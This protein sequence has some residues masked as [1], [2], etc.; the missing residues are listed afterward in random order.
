MAEDGVFFRSVARIDPRFHTPVVS[1]WLQ[2]AWAIVLVMTGSY[3][4]LFTWV[5]FAVVVFHVAT[6]SAVFV[7]RRRQP[8]VPRPYRVWGYP[9]IPALFIA[10]MGAVVV[11]TL[12]VRPVESLLGLLAIATGWPAF[13]WWQAR[14]STRV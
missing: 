13:A 4:Q 14:S 11:S 8:D 1:L 6:A 2:S 7:L 5:T 12:V 3:V 9:W 10:G